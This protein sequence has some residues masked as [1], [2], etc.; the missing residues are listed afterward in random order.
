MKQVTLSIRSKLTLLVV[1]P[2]VLLGGALPILSSI[3]HKELIEAADDR[4]EDAQRA[5]LAEMQDDL[6]DLHLAARIIAHHDAT[7]RALLDG[8]PKEA[9]DVANV[10]SDLYPAR[11][12]AGRPQ[13][14]GSG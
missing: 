12:Y 11:H 14:Q 13:W 5:F 7:L 2:L 9:L 1:L 10:F 3:Q 8:N 6:A 4:V